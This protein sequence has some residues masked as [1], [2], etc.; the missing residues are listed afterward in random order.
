[1][2]VIE[3]EETCKTVRLLRPKGALLVHFESPDGTPF[4]VPKGI[5]EAV[6]KLTGEIT[7]IIVGAIGATSS[8]TIRQES[9]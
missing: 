9:N 2:K 3:L 8:I 7:N 4:K 6:F 1:M 5:T